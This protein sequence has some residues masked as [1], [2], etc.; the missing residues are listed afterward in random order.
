MKTPDLNKPVY[1]VFSN[2]KFAVLNKI[3]PTCSKAIKEE[4]FKDELSIKEYGI[5]GMC[6]ICQDDVFDNYDDDLGDYI[7]F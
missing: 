5:S 1:Q 3:C 7:E 6:Q 4:D 2:A